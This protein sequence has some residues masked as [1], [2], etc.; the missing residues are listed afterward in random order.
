MAFEMKTALN[1]A[2]GRSE[3]APEVLGRDAIVLP[4]K[5]LRL[6]AE[7]TSTASAVEGLL[8]EAALRSNAGS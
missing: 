5:E 6:G 1:T 3:Y 4:M 2:P 8:K 7:S